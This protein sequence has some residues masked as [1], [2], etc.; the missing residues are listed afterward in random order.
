MTAGIS[1]GEIDVAFTNPTPPSGWTIT[2]AQGVAFP[3]Q[4]PSLIFQDVIQFQE[5]T[6]TFNS[7]TFTGLTP[8][9]NYCVSAWLQW[10]KP[11][12]KTAYSVSV[13][14]IQAAAT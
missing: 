8:T 12:G 7:L 3:D 14:D 10:Q 13:T 6:A 2:A 11:D 4:D 5:D 9:A 1:S